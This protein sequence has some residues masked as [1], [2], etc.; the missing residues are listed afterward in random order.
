MNILRV[1]GRIS[2]HNVGFLLMV[3]YVL[4]SCCMAHNHARYDRIKRLLDQYTRSFTLLD[5]GALDG[6]MVSAIGH[7]YDVTMVVISRDEGGELELFCS[8]TDLD[9]LILLKKN[10]SL[11]HLQRLSEC[12]HFDVTLI[13]DGFN[14]LPLMRKLMIQ[15]VVAL[16]DYTVIEV[17]HGYKKRGSS[18]RTDEI[19]AYLIE[20]QATILEEVALH[21]SSLFI[22][23]KPKTCLTRSYWNN[24]EKAP[25]GAY[26]ITSTFASKT[27]YKQALKSTTSWYPGINLHTFKALNGVYPTSQQL[28]QVSGN[29]VNL[30][31]NDYNPCN[32]ILQG[33]CSLQPI[34][35]DDPRRNSDWGVGYHRLLAMVAA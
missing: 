5:I 10:L 1:L 13:L 19:R 8:K 26:H 29:L 24:A 30:V 14:T 20:N 9:R 34:D 3:M 33:R 12:E 4:P 16:G 28:E 11:A 25:E 18:T 35:F 31:H 32:F 27:L 7:A 21:D 22:A 6:W 23:H 17:P 2:V 15:Y